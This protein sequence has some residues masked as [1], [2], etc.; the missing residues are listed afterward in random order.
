MMFNFLKWILGAKLINAL[1]ITTEK[2]KDKIID[3]TVIDVK[4]G[5]RRYSIAFIKTTQGV[6]KLNLGR[7]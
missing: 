4:K 5:K 2:K 3:Q 6:F 7:Y 1:Y